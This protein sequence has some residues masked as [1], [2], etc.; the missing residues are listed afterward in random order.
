M[1][2]PVRFYFADDT[3]YDGFTDDTTWNG[4]DNIWVTAETF[5]KV[6]AEWEKTAG[7]DDRE[8]LDEL[9]SQAPDEDGHYSFAYGYA[10]QIV[11][12]DDAT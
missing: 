10:T 11:D 3:E 4:F 5:E 7:P 9:K 6:L 8:H 12:P 2:R 1:K